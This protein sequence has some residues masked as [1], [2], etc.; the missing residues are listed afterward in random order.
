[1]EIEKIAFRS[2]YFS[3]I[4]HKIIPYIMFSLRKV[5]ILDELEEENLRV[6]RQKSWFKM[7]VRR[8]EL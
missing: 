5:Q 8:K 2:Y 7:Y 3:K 4:A 1:M 6:T